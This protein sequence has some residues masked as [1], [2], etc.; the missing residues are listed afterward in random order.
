[1]NNHIMY[2][3]FNK[4]FLLSE[5]LDINRIQSLKFSM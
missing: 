1:M 3:L 2:F 4:R 5:K